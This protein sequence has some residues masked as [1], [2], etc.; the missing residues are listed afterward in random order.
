MDY[1][2]SPKFIPIRYYST[3]LVTP[4]YRYKQVLV[5][6]GRNSRRSIQCQST[7]LF[8]L[9]CDTLICNVVVVRWLNGTK[10]LNGQDIHVP[11]TYPQRLKLE[12]FSDSILIDFVYWLQTETKKFMHHLP[13][14]LLSFKCVLVFCIVRSR[15]ESSPSSN[16]IKMLEYRYAT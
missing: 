9:C 7:H 5:E 14:L 16:H 4:Y 12:T 13:Y 3:E 2:Y 15:V 6:K 8:Y 11:G 1:Q 10:P